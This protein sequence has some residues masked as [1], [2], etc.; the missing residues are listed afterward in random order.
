[1]ISLDFCLAHAFI[2]IGVRES[3]KVDFSSSMEKKKEKEDLFYFL[4][5]FSLLFEKRETMD[6]K[7]F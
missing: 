7:P 3:P 2:F 1:K 6:D 5:E 4:Q